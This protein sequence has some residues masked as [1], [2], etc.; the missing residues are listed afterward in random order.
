M[1]IKNFKAGIYKQQYKYRS[2]MP[3]PVNIEWQAGD[4]AVINLLSEADTELGADAG[5]RLSFYGNYRGFN[6]C[7]DVVESI[8]FYG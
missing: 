6:T 8:C 3:N 7:A 2:F 5:E 4:S 1:D